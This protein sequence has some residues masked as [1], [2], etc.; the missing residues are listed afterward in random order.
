MSGQDN[1]NPLK[2]PLRMVQPKYRIIRGVGNIAHVT[3]IADE[4]MNGV[5]NIFYIVVPTAA[6]IGVCGIGKR[7]IFRLRGDELIRQRL[8]PA[9]R[10]RTSQNISDDL[11][12][13]HS[14]ISI[15]L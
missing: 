14:R 15:C 12:Q 3:P 11:L 13:R 6:H 7:T 2:V 4:T 5:V 10:Q 9:K 8:E 1:C